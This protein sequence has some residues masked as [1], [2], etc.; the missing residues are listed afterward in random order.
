MSRSMFSVVLVLLGAL[1]AGGCQETQLST[2][3]RDPEAKQLSFQK[4]V[5]IV[6]HSTPAERR[7]QED[8]IAEV[9]HR[10]QAVP[11]YTFIA[12]ADLGKRDVV[13]RLVQEQ[14]FDG[15]VVLRLVSSDTRTTYSVD[16]YDRGW[17]GGWSLHG[18]TDARVS[19]FTD[20]FI[21]A[22]VS[23]YDVRT[24]R[25]VWAGSAD[26]VNPASARDFALG[27]AQAAAKE[28]RKQ[29]LLPGT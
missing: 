1:L 17:D 23:L 4:V 25:L 15:A 14:G 13:K 5:V 9:I 28:L 18:V 8:A 26:A 11:S 24:S 10:A 27:V 12:D 7:A 6:L 19:S 21:R 2:S 22:D 29:R 3:W 16:T 20:T